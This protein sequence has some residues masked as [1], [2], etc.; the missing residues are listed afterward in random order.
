MGKADVDA[1]KPAQATHD[2]RNEVERRV[3]QVAEPITTRLGLRLMSVR[4]HGTRTTGTLRLTIDKPGGVT[5]EDCTRVSRAVGHALDVDAPMDHR[6]TLEVSSPGLDRPLEGRNDFE[7]AVGRLVRLKTA[8]SWEG[9]RVVLG[10]LTG[11]EPGGVAVDA[12]GQRWSV[13][14]EAIAQARLEVEW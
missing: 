1:G 6:Y 2:E 12:E 13:P 10:R 3:A 8:P 7:Q 14:W 9:P 5:L 4:Y 11:L